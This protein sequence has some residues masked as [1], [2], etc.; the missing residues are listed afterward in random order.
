MNRNFE[1]LA[2]KSIKTWKQIDLI[3]KGKYQLPSITISHIFIFYFFKYLFDLSNSYI[4]YRYGIEL[5]ILA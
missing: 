2:Q 1:L 5:R 4:Y 3:N